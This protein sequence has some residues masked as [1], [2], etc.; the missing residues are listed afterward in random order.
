MQNFRLLRTKYIYST[1]LYLFPV[2]LHKASINKVN[3]LLE[4]EYTRDIS[5][6][7]TQGYAQHCPNDSIQSKQSDIQS[8]FIKNYNEKKYIEH[9]NYHKVDNKRNVEDSLN[10]SLNEEYKMNETNVEQ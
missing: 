7:I 10:L 3:K 4:K 5:N 9:N 6:L 8:N 2:E 1:F